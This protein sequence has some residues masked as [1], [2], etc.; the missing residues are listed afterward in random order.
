M[1]G[2]IK[3]LFDRQWGVVK[4][5]AVLV[6]TVIICCCFYFFILQSSYLSYKEKQNQVVHERERL[7][8]LTKLQVG[9]N[10]VY[11][12]DL[13]STQRIA[14]SLNI[15]LEESGGVT[16]RQMKI[17][18]VN[19]LG[20]FYEHRIKLV[21]SGH[22]KNIMKYVKVI[23]EKEPTLYWHKMDY[24][25]QK[26]PFSIVTFYVSIVNDEKYWLST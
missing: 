16:V 14:K 20:R 23:K 21:V 26:Y 25:V 1:I 19:K 24:K 8:Q 2:D 3:V 4:Y 22:Y 5:L 7:G 12:N 13:V 11:A 18:P 10:N 17:F 6:I 15:A 9:G